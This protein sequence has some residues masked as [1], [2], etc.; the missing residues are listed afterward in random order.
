MSQ[1]SELATRWQWAGWPEQTS[2]AGWPEQTSRL[3]RTHGS[4]H[5]RRPLLTDTGRGSGA[6]TRP[7]E[8][9]EKSILLLCPN[10]AASNSAPPLEDLG[11]AAS[12][13]GARLEPRPLCKNRDS[14]DD[15][16]G[17]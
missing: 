16:L 7:T 8:S 17:V 11:G 2:W 6:H 13:S 5:H 4:H 12:E 15:E 9:R 14:T 3:L 10:A 1:T